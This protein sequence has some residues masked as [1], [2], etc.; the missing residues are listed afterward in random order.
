MTRPKVKDSKSVSYSLDTEILE[1]LE[2]YSAETLIPK[3]RVVEQA[4]KEYIE[5][6]APKKK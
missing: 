5:A 6:R 3:T 4:I 1:M 2:R